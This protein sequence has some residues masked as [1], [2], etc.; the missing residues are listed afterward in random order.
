MLDWTEI[1]L[2]SPPVRCCLTVP[3]D[4]WVLPS[5]PHFHLRTIIFSVLCTRLPDNGL[6]KPTNKCNFDFYQ[7]DNKGPKGIWQLWDPNCSVCVYVCR[8]VCCSISWYTNGGTSICFSVKRLMLKWLMDELRPVNASSSSRSVSVCH[9]NRT[10]KRD[11]Q[12]LFRSGS[13]LPFG[14]STT[15]RDS[16]LL[17]PCFLPA[18]SSVLGVLH[19]Q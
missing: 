4:V 6:K 14:L 12:F 19:A 13:S 16:P 10:P 2:G 8:C 1:G 9:Y 5:L 11:H 7:P 18:I 3:R 15:A 17:C